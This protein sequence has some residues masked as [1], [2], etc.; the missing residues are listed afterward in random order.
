VYVTIR[1]HTCEAR[2]FA[3]GDRKQAQ[4]VERQVQDT[5]ALVVEQHV[6]VDFLQQVSAEPQLCVSICT[7]V[8]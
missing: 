6:F 7:F 5:E 8:L 2:Q 4:L 3:D 1:E